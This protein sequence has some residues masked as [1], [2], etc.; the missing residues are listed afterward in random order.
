V[1]FGGGQDRRP[2]GDSAR[3][4]DIVPTW[5][6]GSPA[7]CSSILRVKRSL[8]PLPGRVARET[9]AR[10]SVPAVFDSRESDVQA[11]GHPHI[12]TGAPRAQVWPGLGAGATPVP[13]AIAI[14]EIFNGPGNQ[15][16]HRFADV[17]LGPFQ[18]ALR[19]LA[20][21]VSELRGAGIPLEYLDFWR[22]AGRSHYTNE[23]FPREKS[24]RGWLRKA[25]RPLALAI[26]CWSL[27]ERS[28]G[29]RGCC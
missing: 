3:R 14:R 5:R 11:G 15:R 21:Y 23:K 4:C 8:R 12:S 28:S 13:S 24:T 2:E 7:S 19:R 1:I 16:A 22:G 6:R 25:I 9:E 26:F 17:E 27:D 10:R 20:G 29:R 18:R